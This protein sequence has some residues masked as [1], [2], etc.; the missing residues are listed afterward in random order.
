[1]VRPHPLA[2]PFDRARLLFLWRHGSY[3]TAI[4]DD[5]KA[6]GPHAPHLEGRHPARTRREESRYARRD[7]FQVYYR[8][9]IITPAQTGAILNSLSSPLH[10]ALVL[11]CAATALRSSEILALRWADVHWHE[12][13]IQISALSENLERPNKRASFR[14][15]AVRLDSGECATTNSREP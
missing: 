10:Y 2:T 15:E 8:A 6:A 12:G 7:A 4:I 9:I 13:G 11:T 1:M 3:P 14:E 5:S